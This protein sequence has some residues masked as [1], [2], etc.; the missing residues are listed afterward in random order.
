[1]RN[2]QDSAILVSPECAHG[3]NNEYIHESF[4]P[5]V[6]TFQIVCRNNIPFLISQRS[7]PSH[8]YLNNSPSLT[9]FVECHSPWVCFDNLSSDTANL[10]RNVKL[11]F[12]SSSLF[13]WLSSCNFFRI[14]FS[15]RSKFSNSSSSPHVFG[16]GGI[17]GYFGF[18]IGR[19]LGLRI[20][21]FIP[22]FSK[23]CSHWLTTPELVMPKCK[24]A[25]SA[26]NCPFLTA[27]I[28]L[29]LNSGK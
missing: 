14:A 1:M 9:Y 12:A 20:K 2:R 10:G 28:M 18:M 17:L 25:A 23:A 15:A 26:E 19:L 29:S 16:L 3:C 22:C 21:P 7:F 6:R 5:V 11:G 27:C 4:F 24:Y 13:C 8:C